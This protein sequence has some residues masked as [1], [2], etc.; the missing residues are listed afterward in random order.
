MAK[1]FECKNTIYPYTRVLG[2]KFLQ[3]DFITLSIFQCTSPGINIYPFGHLLHHTCQKLS[4]SNFP[5]P[6]HLT[7]NVTNPRERSR[8]MESKR[9][10]FR[11]CPP[12]NHPV[13]PTSNF[14]PCLVMFRSILSSAIS[15]MGIGLAALPF[16]RWQS[17]EATPSPTFM[18]TRWKVPPASCLRTL[19]L[20]SSIRPA[21]P[22]DGLPSRNGRETGL[23]M[24]PALKIKPPRTSE[25]PRKRYV[26]ASLRL[27]YS[28][29]C[30]RIQQAKYLNLWRR[31]ES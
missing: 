14:Q 23:S 30:E 10:V 17:A 28:T 5:H 19:T 8:M 20:P 22:E 9:T 31:F 7:Q 1:W 21:T 25:R 11:L 12:V 26:A 29:F 15:A 3:D 4:H 6:R 27:R 24:P 2:S 16:N 18:S 13:T